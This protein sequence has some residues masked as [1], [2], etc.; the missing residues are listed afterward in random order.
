MK[1]SQDL[2]PIRS[3]FWVVRTPFPDNSG[4]SLLSPSDGNGNIFARPARYLYAN[5]TYPMP[6]PLWWWDATTRNAITRIDGGTINGNRSGLDNNWHL[7]SLTLLDGASG[8]AQAFGADRPGYEEAIENFPRGFR[9]GGIA[10]AEVLV[11][12]RALSADEVK[13][14]EA[15]LTAKWF[16]AAPPG[17]TVDG[18]GHG[19][20][21]ITLAP[22]GALVLDGVPRSAVTVTGPGTVM[23]AAVPPTAWQVAG[24]RAFDRGL[25]LADGATV[26]VDYDGNAL[27]A[28]RIDVAGGLTVQGSGTL[29]FA[30]V[31]NWT[32]GGKT[33]PVFAYDALTG[34]HNWNALWRGANAPRGTTIQCL[35]DTD[36]HL[37]NAT[38][39]PAGTILLIR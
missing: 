28:G 36:A 29:R 18:Q 19:G 10:Y 30:S 20:V 6:R 27:T 39:N 22:G 34:G 35:T 25:T 9:C 1:W 32:P 3:V 26:Y 8:G 12:N 13:S 24:P 37:L 33:F 4:G 2:W 38:F 16:R 23:D 17:V 5:T 7:L 14:V 21:S 15:Y 11:Y 31:S